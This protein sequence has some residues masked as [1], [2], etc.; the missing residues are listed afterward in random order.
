VRTVLAIRGGVPKI[1]PFMMTFYRRGQTRQS[2][3]LLRVVSG[4]LLAILAARCAAGEDGPPPLP[5]PPMEPGTEGLA[6]PK[7]KKP[8]D[9]QGMNWNA[10]KMSLDQ[11]RNALVL[12]GSAVLS[13]QGIKLE[14]DNIVLFRETKEIYAEGNV[15]MRLGESEISAEAAYIDGINTTGFLV[16]AVVRVSGS[17]EDLK[18]FKALKPHST[19]KHDG[20]PE[21]LTP[22]NTP[23][24]GPKES[25]PVD[26]KSFLRTRD[27]YGTYVDVA[28]D[29]QARTNLIMKAEKVIIH[30]KEHLTAE[31]AFATNDD[32]VHPLYGV[33]AQQLD[34]FSKEVPDPQNPG[35][36]QLVPDK[37]VGKGATL[38]IYGVNLFPFPTITYDLQKKNAFTQ[39]HFGHSQRFGYFGLTRIGFGM[40]GD[41]KRLFDPQHVYFDLD[42]RTGRGPAAGF[43]MDWETGRRP[44]DTGPNQDKF[45]RGEGHVR[46]YGTDEIQISNYQDIVR[47]RRDLERRIEPKIDGF[48]MRSF[49]PNLLFAQRRNLENAGPPDLDLDLYAGK[50]RGMFSIQQH[51]PLKRFAGIDNLLLDFKFE[52]DSDRDFK[53]EYFENNYLRENQP[54]GLFSTRK[55]S[56]N[57]SMELLYRGNPQNFDGAP[58]RSPLD[59]GTFT[60]YEPALTYSLVTTPLKYGIYMDTELQGARLKRDF[61]RQIYDQ[62]SFEADRAYGIIDFSRPTK[63]GSVNVVPHLGGQQQVYDETR[64]SSNGAPQ[65]ALTYGLDMTSRY[66]GL[67]PDLQNDALALK[68]MRHIIETRME[69]HG[70]SDTES[71][72]KD[73]L[74]FDQI[75]DL[76]RQDKITFAIDQVAQ[77]KRVDE[78]GNSHTYNFAG[79]NMSLGVFP[80]PRDQN[81]INDG[82]AL[83]LYRLDG[84]LRVLEVLKLNAALGVQLQTKQLQESVF[85]IEIDPHTRWR[86]K[87]EDRFNYASQRR[88]IFGSDQYHLDFAYRLS[89]RW[90]FNFEEIVERRKSLQSNKGRQVERIGFT[91]SYGSFDGTFTYSEDRNNRDH[92]TYFTVKPAVVY[93]NVIVPSQDLLVPPAEVSG[94]GEAP[95][96][97][98]FDPFDLLRQRNKAKKKDNLGPGKSNENAPVPP[99]PPSDN[100]VP[101]PPPPDQKRA[102]APS[103]DRDTAAGSFSDPRASEPAAERKRVDDDD[104]TSPAA[105]P[106]S[107]R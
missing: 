35:K 67:F 94:D 104:W 75:D 47:A 105:T 5:P 77:T 91:R 61:D 96:E 50:F 93:R 27:P 9:V 70:I 106:A 79:L 3:R 22:A 86:L 33:V 107:T 101:A 56:D 15:R 100:D 88:T 74:D 87:L 24:G 58:A 18:K 46:F 73:L 29:P 20:D 41:E 42:E 31:N 71:R 36:T 99:A 40:G 23:G 26:R 84:F 53:L 32:M 64:V 65:G 82:Y 54:E 55:A 59:Y 83:D 62:N 95:E 37:V 8:D 2:T 10:V 21:E 80:N 6:P 4:L 14:G 44:V 89:E 17:K 57:Y 92:S 12:T 66:Y 13:Y 16:D 49:D 72:P 69:Y 103:R 28:D 38:Q 76:F 1:N 11:E 85:G 81:R 52:R 19:P 63:F 34:F 60:N 39:A 78:N 48:P 102:S 7:P 98:N 30:G 45:E 43:E 51:Q 68:G 90:A 25:I 97:R